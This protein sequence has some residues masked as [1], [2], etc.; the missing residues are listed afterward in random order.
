MSD[1]SSTKTVSKTIT[2]QAVLAGAF[3]Y[4]P[5]AP[6]AGETVQF[7]DA[8]TGGPTSWLWNFGDT[9][10]S[11]EQ[12]P[13]HSFIIG[14]PYV[15]TLT[16]SNGSSSKTCSQTVTI[17]ADLD[18]QFT[19]SP[20]S[21]SVNE[22]VLFADASTGDTTSWKWDFGD[23]TTSDLK[24][25]EHTFSEMGTFDVSLTVSDGSTSKSKSATIIVGSLESSTIYAAS[26]EL[27]D[28]QDAVNRASAGNIVIVP[29]GAAVWAGQLLI[30]KGIIL[31][32]ESVG[33]VNITADMS[34]TKGAAADFLIYYPI[35][36]PAAGEPFRISGF[37]I[38]L[39]G[40]CEGILIENCSVTPSR[41]NRIDNNQIT[42]SAGRMIKV[43]GTV[44]G[45]VDNNVLDLLGVGLLTTYGLNAESWTALTFTPGS[46]DNWY[47]EDNTVYMYSTAHDGGVGGRYASRYNKYINKKGG[48]IYPIMDLH[49]NMG[50]GGN[51]AGMGI[52][53]YGNTYDMSGYNGTLLDLRGGRCI[54]YGNAV[55]N[56]GSS[57]T[58]KVREEN[59]DSLNPPDVSPDGEPQHVS[60]SYFWSYVK[61]GSKVTT[62][63]PFV[64]GSFDYAVEGVVPRENVHFWRESESFDGTAG[65]GTGLLADRPAICTPGVAYWAT[66]EQK[67]Y[68]CESANVWTLYYVPYAYPHPLRT[69]LNY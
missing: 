31:K 46:A 10:T 56:G 15:V 34:G 42:H 16:I 29:S 19:F 20:S 9:T 68:R 11:S 65:V 57:V 38:D 49:G 50:T 8:S 24:D 69:S 43:R 17:K 40:K 36:D 21:P 64:G 12:N 32:A 27:A 6:A 44:Y 14:A 45:V 1:S 3:S 30:S 60:N 13:S 67:L 58:F 53:V 41:K 59:D 33:G 35:T 28:V 37:N 2:V 22:K 18:A 7:T 39:A 61:D 5:A 62:N 63:N 47:Y 4:T 51:L 55:V 25:P 66:D 23:G 26:P 48:N 54:F 52:E